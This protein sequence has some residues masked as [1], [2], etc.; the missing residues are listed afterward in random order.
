MAITKMWTD[1]S[2]PEF[3]E[4]A[5]C[6][7][8]HHRNGGH[9]VITYQTHHGLCLSEREANGYHD[10]DFYMLVWDPEAG[11]P[12]EIMFATTRGW[13][14]PCYASRADATPEVLA[15][16]AD[17]QRRQTEE[18]RKRAAV[19]EATIPRV[20]RRIRVVKSV[21]R[22]KNKVEGGAE[23]VVT[24]F[25]KDGFDRSDRYLNDMQRS[26]AAMIR[27]PRDGMRVG[28]KFDDG[29][30][31]FLPAMNVEVIHATAEAA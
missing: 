7:L 25:G 17:W 13:S 5:A 29:R 15:A 11:K 18:D 24:W 4:G 12:N 6:L 2:A 14:Y 20:D 21:T 10:S 3:P 8:E 27:D 28:V 30:R 26:I 16:Y 22:G 19:R 31:L 23:G 9:V 1:N